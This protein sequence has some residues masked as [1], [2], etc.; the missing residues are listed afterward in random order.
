V[1][2]KFRIKTGLDE[3]KI[4]IYFFLSHSQSRKLHSS[5]IERPRC[6]VLSYKEFQK[7]AAELCS[8]M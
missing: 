7:Y 6:K 4:N 8:A 1:V 2:N 3:I 5:G